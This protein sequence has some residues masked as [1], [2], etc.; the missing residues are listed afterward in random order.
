MGAT[1]ESVKDAQ[2]IQGRKE[3]LID[4]IRGRLDDAVVVEEV[5]P[6]VVTLSSASGYSVCF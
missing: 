3:V 2:F 6:Y 1:N 4:L 5:F